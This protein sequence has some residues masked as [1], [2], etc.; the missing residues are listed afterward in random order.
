MGIVA[1]VVMM[2]GVVAMVPTAGLAEPVTDS[3]RGGG[4]DMRPENRYRP[5]SETEV[6][7]ALERSLSL[8]ECIRIGLSQN[9][10]LR[11]ARNELEKA[12]T[13]HYGSYG[14]FLPVLSIQ[15]TKQ[16]SR[17]M[18]VLRDTIAPHELIMGRNETLVGR[19]TQTLPTGALV[20]LSHD[21]QNDLPITVRNRSF[22]ASVTQPLFRGAWP[23]A[24]TSSVADAEY[25][26]EG[27]ERDLDDAMRQTVL[28]VRLAYYDVVS[29]RELVRVSEDAVKR[30]ST[31][32]QVSD[33]MLAAKIA[34]RRDVLSAEIRLA[35]D[36]ATLVSTQKDYELSLDNLKETLG[37]PLDAPISLADAQLTYSPVTVDEEALVRESLENSPS[38][39][40]AALAVSRSRLQLKVARNAGLPRL[41]LTGSYSKAFNADQPNAKDTRNTDW[42]AALNV[43]YPFLN[44]DAASA[45]DIARLSLA[46]EQDR[47]GIL[48][49]RITVKVR[50]AV[51]TLRSISEEIAAVQ[52][53]IEAAE[54]KVEFATAMF[55][56]GRASNLDITDAQQALLK[57]RTQYVRRLVDYHAQLGTLESL[58]GLPL[59]D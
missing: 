45:A 40:S 20:S 42:V 2:A 31:L 16:E 54:E 47:L 18:S 48:Q 30:D 1:G 28:E 53:A 6:Q 59:A 13:A 12:E 25:Q 43:S 44:R 57:S 4:S 41:D 3:V 22:S 24:A 38:I 7:A 56:L 50:A 32:V 37:L 5:F 10:P 46:Q 39:E 33:A 55:N 49:R 9:I 29:N 27:R 51:R 14:K 8:Q 11:I 36:R 19:V 26:R 34:T 23:T 35:D 58:T 17:Q 15:G 21:F 52:R